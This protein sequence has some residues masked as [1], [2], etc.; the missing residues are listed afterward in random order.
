MVK[1][2][3]VVGARPNF[4]KIAPIM[5]EMKKRQE[6]DPIL[7]HTGQHYDDEMSRLFFIDLDLPAPNINLNV[8]SGLHGEQ[9][10]RVMIAFEKVVLAASPDLVLVVGDVNSTLACALVSS[11]LHVKVAHVEAGLRSFDRRMPEEINRILTDQIAD[12][13]FTTSRGAGANLMREGISRDKIAFVGNVMVDT[14][15]RNREK[16]LGSTVLERYGLSEGGYA[17]LTLHRPYNVDNQVIFEKLLS[18]L[19]VIQHQIRII[20]PAHPRTRRRISEF[21]L[22]SAVAAI[23]NLIVCEPLGY[24]DFLKLMGDAKLVLTDSGGIQE[25]TTVLGIPCLTLRP[26]TERPITVEQG[27]NVVVGNNTDRIIEE[28][29]AILE[30]HG[31]CGK[32]PELWDGKAAERIVQRLLEKTVD[33]V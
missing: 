28:T 12:Y 13:L 29:F 3:N 23:P 21:G 24:L 6:I 11:K 15:L 10:G 4:M 27:T 26:V 17:V 25:E 8:G 18:A 20:F 30:G 16:A 31:R 9:T 7:V 33:D 14:L 32:V 22:D 2:I 5:T 19:D 1:I